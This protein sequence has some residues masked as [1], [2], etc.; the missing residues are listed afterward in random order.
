MQTRAD[1]NDTDNEKALTESEI[2]RR[3][4]ALCGRL[5]G[6]H[7]NLM[8]KAPIFTTHSIIPYERKRRKSRARK[9]RWREGKTEPAQQQK[10]S[11]HTQ[12][13]EEKIFEL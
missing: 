12:E 13:K 6:L 8:F 10:R 5:S 4:S 11:S 3:H 1:V 2:K 7:G 9:E